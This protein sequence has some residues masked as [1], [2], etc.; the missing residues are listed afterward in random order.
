MKQ[1]FIA[2]AGLIGCCQLSTA[3]EKA[4]AKVHYIFKHVNDTTLQDN[5]LRDEVVTYLGRSSSYYTTYSAT[6]AQEEMEKQISDPEFDGNLQI[7]KNVTSVRE[8]YLLEF[9]EQNAQEVVTVASDKFRLEG[10]Y[11]A[12]DWEIEEEVRTIGGYSA[13]KASTTFKGRDYTAWFT[14]ELPFPAGPWKLNGLPGLI[15]EAYDANKEVVFEYSGFDKMEDHELYIVVP[16]GTLEST[17]EEVEK[18]Y[19]AYRANPQAYSQTKRSGR[20]VAPSGVQAVGVVPKAAPMDPNKLKSI[21]IKN[22]DDY[23]PSS[24]TNNPIELIP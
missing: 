6:R 14:T 4:V 23:K 13:Q 19:K 24:D 8:S 7:N 2:F 12:Q 21:E 1:L 17:K 22:A 15:L 5:S 9:A 11:P 16:D 10:V 3:Q 20:S 18:L